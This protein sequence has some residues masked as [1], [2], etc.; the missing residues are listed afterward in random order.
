MKIDY[1]DM[2]EC[3]EK[4][5]THPTKCWIIEISVIRDICKYSFT[6]FLD[7]RFS[8]TKEFHIIILKPMFSLSEMHTI[9]IFVIFDFLGNPFSYIR[10]YSTI[11]RI[12]DDDHHRLI[13]LHF[14]R[15]SR[16]IGD[17]FE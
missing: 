4:V 14:I 1:I 11:R 6:I 12:P 7:E 9:D 3:L 5:P 2:I 17:R 15:L 10:R 13:S 8:E 16:L